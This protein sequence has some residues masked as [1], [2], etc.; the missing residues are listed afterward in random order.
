MS[1]LVLGDTGMLQRGGMGEVEKHW[2]RE[3]AAYWADWEVMGV[4]W[5]SGG[6]WRNGEAGALGA[7]GILGSWDSGILV[8][9]GEIVGGFWGMSGVSREGSSAVSARWNPTVPL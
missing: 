3:I 2:G 6:C 4:L 9:C 8:G 7:L 5:D 1:I